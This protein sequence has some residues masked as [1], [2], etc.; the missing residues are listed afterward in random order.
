MV[1]K[2]STYSN[3][4]TQV[5]T[6]AGAFN[7]AVNHILPGSFS[8]GVKI[9][10]HQSAD[11]GFQG[12]TAIA[13]DSMPTINVQPS[14][15]PVA[16]KG[17]EC[18]GLVSDLSWADAN[19]LAGYEYITIQTDPSVSKSEKLYFVTG[20]LNS[21]KTQ[22][23]DPFSGAAFQFAACWAGEYTIGLNPFA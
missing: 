4:A 21:T 5:R 6:A 7:A 11:G 19:L 10:E 15:F 22:A 1:I 20:I 13:G 18:G 12:A 14:Y 16:T 8:E 2:Q 17:A 9:Y 3:L 23:N